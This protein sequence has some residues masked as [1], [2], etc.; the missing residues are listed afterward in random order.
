MPER[1][2]STLP[3]FLYL[4]TYAILLLLA[5][6]AA[7][8]VPL[9]RISMWFLPAQLILSLICLK[10]SIRLFRSWKDKKRKYAVLMERNNMS[11]EEAHRYLQKCSMESGTNMVET[12]HMVLTIM[13]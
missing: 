5:G 13:D 9:Y 2:I 10:N 8:L 1:R 3:R 4:N 12:A 11:E 6:M 7:V